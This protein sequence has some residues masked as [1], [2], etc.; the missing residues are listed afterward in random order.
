MAPRVAAQARKHVDRTLLPWKKRD[1]V[2]PAEAW[3]LDQ[4]VPV[5]IED[6]PTEVATFIGVPAIDPV[7]R[8]CEYQRIVIPYDPA[9][10]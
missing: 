7:W 8:D 3:I 1:S 6:L 9:R 5:R 4:E 10:K 2:V